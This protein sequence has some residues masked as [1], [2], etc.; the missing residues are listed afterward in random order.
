[1]SSPLVLLVELDTAG[2]GSYATDVTAYVRA[3][4]G[5]GITRGRADEQ[6]AP[7]PAMLRLAL[8]NRDGRFCPRNPTGPYYGSIGRN[9]G[10]RVTVDGIGTGPSIRFT[11]EVS[12][13]PVL[14]DHSEQDVW[15]TITAAGIRRRLARGQAPLRDALTRATL[16]AADVV[17]YWPMGDVAGNFQPLTPGVGEL[18]AGG[19]IT[20]ADNDTA[21]P[22]VPD[23]P[24]FVTGGSATAPLPAMA[25][26]VV[27]AGM[28]VSIPTG[29]GG[30]VY[31]LLTVAYI[32]GGVGFAELALLANTGQLALQLF[33]HT[34]AFIVGATTGVVDDIRDRPVRLQMQ[35]SQ[36]GANVDLALGVSEDG[37]TTTYTDTA[38]ALTLGTPIRIGLGNPG[39]VTPRDAL[40]GVVAGQL[41]VQDSLSSA[42]T[43]LPALE[44]YAGELAD[45]RILRLCTEEGIP[46]FAGGPTLAGG[47]VPLGPQ[48]PGTLLSLL[49][50]AAFA[51]G[52]ILAELQTG[53]GFKYTVHVDLYNQDP[54]V[55]LS[56]G[57]DFSE[58]E[59]T[60]DDQVVVNDLTATRIGGGDYRYELT[61][62]PLSVQ[63]PPDGVNRYDSTVN[64][65]LEADSQLRD[66]ASWRVHVATVDEPRYP[67]LGTNLLRLTD[68]YS[69]VEVDAILGV[70]E[71]DP[72]L[73]TTPPT[74]AGAPDDVRQLVAGWRELI[75][76][77]TYDFTLVGVPA[78]PWDVGVFDDTG[79]DLAEEPGSRYSPDATVTAEALDTTETGIDVS[80]PSG[81]VWTTTGGEYPFDINIGGERITVGGA[82]GAGASQ[83]FT[84]CTRSVNGVV[85]SHA[86]GAPVTLWQPA[87]YAY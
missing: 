60:E 72:V 3:A 19:A 46:L 61:T 64:L 21:F 5:V 40:S 45:A 55:A 20:Y 28:L 15:V 36:N 26:G 77:H 86:S 33:D 11:G 67:V 69:D 84:G 17:A 79:D 66:Q 43:L 80:T 6:A 37:S 4:G 44:R 50:E 56:Y 16:A 38:A 23:L 57:G 59:P 76:T 85:K 18:V 29:L 9:T 13:W 49:D 14:F 87:V 74:F 34:G 81:P 70:S 24:T 63:A 48:L 39:L 58:F 68:P 65:S 1:M 22:G 54:D 52:G 82:S 27:Q 75:G 12:A 71:G 51:D 42:S 2:D 25:S 62:G 8:N 73:I 53:L 7:S 10:I 78:S 30:S 31:S 32:G 83:T 47:G 35:V 41:V